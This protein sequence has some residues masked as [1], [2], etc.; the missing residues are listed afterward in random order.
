MRIL[1]IQLRSYHGA[2]RLLYHRAGYLVFIFRRIINAVRHQFPPDQLAGPC[3]F[4]SRQGGAGLC[5]GKLCF[6]LLHGGLV[7]PGVDHKQ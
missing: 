2:F 5:R 1:E 3:Q 4:V 7:G 6:C